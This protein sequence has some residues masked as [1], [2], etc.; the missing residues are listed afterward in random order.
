MKMNKS[1]PLKI[2]L[3]LNILIVVGGSLAILLGGP[4]TFPGI[5]GVTPSADSEI[6]FMAAFW[7]A[8]GIFTIWVVRDLAAR[9]QFVPWIV[10]FL[11]IGA[12]GRIL[13]WLMVGRPMDTLVTG[14]AVELIIA[15][16]TAVFYYQFRQA[17]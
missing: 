10:L 16:L 2:M 15:G 9:H 11:L 14:T 4:T 1:V 17:N 3:W 8:Y 6:R 12:I 5:E 13:S 7:L